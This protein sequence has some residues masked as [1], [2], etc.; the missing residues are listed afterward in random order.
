MCGVVV[1]LRWMLV[2]D[3]YMRPVIKASLASESASQPPP[4]SIL[5]GDGWC[6]DRALL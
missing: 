3:L 5:D 4:W 2:L 6:T 1:A